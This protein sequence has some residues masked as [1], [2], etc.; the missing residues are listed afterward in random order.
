MRKILFCVLVLFAACKK[1][2]NNNT[3]EDKPTVIGKWYFKSERVQTFKST[4]EL[5]SDHST[6]TYPLNDYIL[7]N[8]DGTGSAHSGPDEALFTYTVSGN[9]ETEIVD[10]KNITNYT[11]TL[12]DKVLKRHSEYTKNGIKNIYDGE[13]AR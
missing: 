3:Q 10:D 6:T 12:T 4:G 1:N 11:I 5:I 2:S 13:Y 7:F 8:A 9:I